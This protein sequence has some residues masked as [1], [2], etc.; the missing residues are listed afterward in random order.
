MTCLQTNTVR[1]S[2]GR[3]LC[4]DNI[5]GL[6]IFSVVLGHLLEICVPF[7][8]SNYL[9]QLIYSFHMPAMIFLLGYFARF[10]LR[11]ILFGWLLPYIVLQ[12]GYICFEKYVLGAAVSLQFRTPHWIL[13]FL[14]V[15]LY[16]QLLIPLYDRKRCLCKILMLGGSLLAALGVGYIDDIGYSG[17]LSRF[18]VFQPFFLLGFYAARRPKK[19]VT[20][21]SHLL[22]ALLSFAAF[23]LCAAIL[24]RLEPSNAMLF[25]AHPYSALGHN[26]AIRGFFMVMGL[27][28]IVFLF[29]GCKH[30]ADRRIPL[31]TCL[32]QNTLS[33]FLLHGFGVKLLGHYFPSAVRKPWGVLLCAGA[34]L[35]IFG[36][37]GVGKAVRFLCS[38][39]WLPFQKKKRP[40]EKA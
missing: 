11:K 3:E 19:A 30:L 26:A 40:A 1:A 35:L 6:L 33:V 15:G 36:N 17:G 13:W 10:S 39:R 9:Y 2:A 8:G 32:G 22:V 24:Y 7:L 20:G 18:F 29:Y 21:R 27:S 5:R 16:Y 25:G 38:D 37:P 12:I 14:V 28:M 31:L 4:Y 34:L 23:A